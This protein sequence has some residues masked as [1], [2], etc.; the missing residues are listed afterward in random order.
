MTARLTAR[1]DEQFEQLERVIRAN[2]RSTGHA[3]LDA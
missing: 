2:L 3:L 1:L